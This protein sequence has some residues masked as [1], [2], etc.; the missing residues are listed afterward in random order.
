MLQNLEAEQALLGAILFDNATLE[1]VG[2]LTAEHFCE[3]VHG[4]IFTAAAAL[5]RRGR[6]ADGQTLKE[7]FLSDGAL[8]EIGGST[9]LMQLM[10]AAAPL[11][12]QAQSYADLIRDL[13]LRR[14]IIGTCSDLTQSALAPKDGADAAD[15][16]L[17]AQHELGR[18]SE[19]VVGAQTAIT[20][21]EAGQRA[22]AALT[23]QRGWRTGLV[24]LDDKLTGFRGGQFILIA[25]APGQGKSALSA[26]IARKAALAGK[27]IHYASYEMGDCDIGERL[28]AVTAYE[29]GK[30]IPY[31]EF[32][33]E[34]QK[35]M[36]RRAE[37]EEV[38]GLIPETLRLEISGP[39]S[40]MALE[41][42]AR[43]TRRKL[44]GLD[45]VFIDY[46][47]LMAGMSKRA[48][49]YE[50]TT[51]ISQ[52]LKALAKRLDAPV[53][54]L[55]QISRENTKR[56]A[57]RRPRLSD[58]R[59]SG[60]LEQDADIVLAVHRE[61]YWLAMDG[62]PAEGGDEALFRYDSEKDR[63]AHILEAIIL[64]QRQGPAG[65]AVPLHFDEQYDHITNCSDIELARFH[66][67]SVQPKSAKPVG[68]GR[69][70]RQW[71]D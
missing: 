20:A 11:S 59:D 22:L 57:N 18:L 46:L 68:K 61:S 32:Q 33:N 42:H 63:W 29:M 52:G 4:R 60:S 25:G 2:E 1:R 62:E 21:R 67:K 9:Y 48:S 28:M 56:G 66:K 45:A 51:E 3:P 49:I 10:D 27:R 24:T 36:A 30:F 34:P 39:Q 64:K 14:Q 40:L 38:I 17:E 65:V 5:I 54:A 71:V 53:F 12:A 50:R 41:M 16:L 8:Q 47:Q 15:A 26:N 44:G 55:T 23:A 13:S 7:F 58:L 70:V 35:W 37:L 43:A 31:F 19:N 69:E 6:V